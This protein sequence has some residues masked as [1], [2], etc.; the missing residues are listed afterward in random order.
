MIRSDALALFIFTLKKASASDRKVGKITVE[1]WYLEN[2]PFLM[3]EPAEK[4]PLQANNW[5]QDH[6]S[7]GL[8]CTVGGGVWWLQGLDGP[9][10]TVHASGG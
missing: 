10:G 4:P 3:P 7:Q 2:H 8:G 1:S 5:L 6:H 9:R